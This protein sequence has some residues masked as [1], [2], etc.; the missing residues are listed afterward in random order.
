MSILTTLTHRPTST[1]AHITITRPTKLNALNTPLLT[2]LPQTLASLT[3]KTP[4]LLC[5]VLTGAGHK[6]F[7]GGADIAE[8]AR[9]DSPASARNF[10]TKVSAACRSVRDCP[11]PVIG[12]VNGYALGAGLEVAASCDFRVASRTAVFGMPEVFDTTT[13][14][15]FWVLDGGWRGV[16]ADILLARS[17][18]VSPAS[19]RRLF[20]LD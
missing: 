12:R 11:V 20:C 3:S 19:L 2:A 6:S 13:F 10:I 16:I 18:L 15:Y 7:I 9:L 4:S 14:F 17:A 5:I 8:M 1:I